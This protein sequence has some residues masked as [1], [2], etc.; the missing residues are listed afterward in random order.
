MPRFAPVCP[1]RMYKE[2][3]ETN[4]KAMGD[5]FLLLAHD[6][7]DKPK[8]YEEIFKDKG[9]TIIMDNS[10]I[11]LGSSVS[12]KALKEACDIVGANILAIPDVLENGDETITSAINF[13]IDWSGH[14]LGTYNDT[15]LMFIPQGKDLKDYVSCMLEAVKYKIPMDWIGIARN[16]TRR[17]ID[18]RQDL[19]GFFSTLAPD[20]KLH[21]LGFSADTEDDIKCAKHPKIQGIDSAVPVRTFQNV[22]PHVLILDPGPREDWWENGELESAQIRNINIMRQIIELD[23]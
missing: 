2:L 11:E 3:Q 13:M 9:Y 18:T 22:F 4:P 6:V 19:I 5:Y 15:E 16:T 1:I 12:A 7:I 20:S 14:T 17:I 10:V 23:I 21:L 8:E